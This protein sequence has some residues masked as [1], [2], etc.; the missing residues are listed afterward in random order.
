[1][2]PITTICDVR[3]ANVLA[4]C[5]EVDRAVVPWYQ[6]PQW[7]FKWARC[8]IDIVVASSR[9]MQVDPVKADSDRIAIM[10][11]S[12]F[13]PSL[14]REILFDDGRDRLDPPTI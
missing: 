12:L 6:G 8:E 3:R 9:R 4:T 2:Q 11:C 7:D 13:T 5:D 1:M 14:E 10:D